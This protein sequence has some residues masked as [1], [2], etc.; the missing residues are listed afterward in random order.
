MK[1]LSSRPNQNGMYSNLFWYSFFESAELMSNLVD[2]L[3]INWDTLTEG[4][5]LSQSPCVLSDLFLLIYLTCL[6]L[7]Q[8]SCRPFGTKRFMVL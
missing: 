5:P 6:L 2:Y 1:K 3:K 7:Q 8:Q 4:V